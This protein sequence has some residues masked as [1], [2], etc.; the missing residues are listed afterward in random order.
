MGHRQLSCPR[1][2]TAI[3][4]PHGFDRPS[5]QCAQCGQKSKLASGKKKP[6]SEKQPPA[7]DPDLYPPTKESPATN[8]DYFPPTWQPPAA[9]S[10]CD[11]PSK[12]TPETNPSN[13]APA[14]PA[15]ATNQADVPAVQQVPVLKPDHTAPAQPAPAL[16]PVDDLA[17]QPALV[18]NQDC[19]PLEQA[20]PL[21]IPVQP[22]GYPPSPLQPLPPARSKTGLILGLS[23]GG[24][25]AA[26]LLVV[27][28]AAAIYL[29]SGVIPSQNDSSVAGAVAD[30][31]TPGASSNSSVS[32]S[33]GALSNIPAGASPVSNFERVF[34]P[35][36]DF[37]QQPVYA[38][39]SS[40]LRYLWNSGEKFAVDFEYEMSD[41]GIAAMTISGR[42]VYEATDQNPSS[43]LPS[44]EGEDL[45]G[46]GT[47]TGF[48]VRPDGYLITCAHVV[49]GAVKTEVELDGQTYQAKVLA[50]DTKND[51]A[52]IRIRAQ[53]LPHLPI[54]DSDR[55]RLAEEVRAFGYPLTDRLGESIKITRGTVSGISQQQDSKVFQLDVT[56][57]PGNSGG[58]LVND[59]GEVAGVVSALLAG[60]HISSMSFAVT[61]NDVRRLMQRT[62]L[63]Y[64]SPDGSA[65]AL[66][67]PDLAEKVRKSVALLKVTTGLGGIG[68]AEKKVVK[69]RNSFSAYMGTKGGSRT[70][71]ANRVTENGVVL[72]DSTGEISYCDGKVPLPG[73]LGL[74]ATVGLQPLSDDET[75]TWQSAR[76][77]LVP[78]THSV[79]VPTVPSAGSYLPRYDPLGRRR[80]RLGLPSTRTVSTLKMHPAVEMTRYEI[81]NT[82][83]NVVEIEKTLDLATIDRSDAEQPY[84]KVTG[85]GK[86]QFDKQRG[87]PK[88]LNFSATV[89]TAS[90]SSSSSA[91]IK[92]SFKAVDPQQGAGNVSGSGALPA[93]STAAAKKAYEEAVARAK[94]V[95]AQKE[96][97]PLPIVPRLDQLD[98]SK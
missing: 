91:N 64:E 33:A 76:L 96:N 53:G 30:T 88:S 90:G 9:N 11:P 85:T 56:V 46:K 15:P 97:A 1:C 94:A 31:T 36:V 61:S 71:I 79:Q 37:N 75:D 51:L 86:L 65:E 92:L 59:K 49:E 26:L 12:Q 44:D 2:G 39:R 25:A 5:I 35:T 60:E 22:S 50:L 69:F 20:D 72:L 16:I 67:G 17:A 68:I 47:G 23:I 66:S 7:A 28:L 10:D 43:V 81:V 87:F 62:G 83:G 42:V 63:K 58:P 29:L 77:T 93:Q 14:D 41:R 32:S 27:V 95:Q 98:L 3:I 6:S 19:D 34:G 13:D 45:E 70:A 73:H 57:N 48:V 21:G 82:S 24:G 4:V 80:H 55:V 89:A 40:G 18:I 74:L 52:L 8:P 84:T 38:P 54:L 78:E